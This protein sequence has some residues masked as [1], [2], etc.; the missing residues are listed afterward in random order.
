MNEDI[1]NKIQETKFEIMT[2]LNKSEEL[3][4]NISTELQSQSDVIEKT[5]SSITEIDSN[6]NIAKKLIG[7]ISSIFSIFKTS[8]GEL[9][10][11]NSDQNILRSNELPEEIITKKNNV[12]FTET[13]QLSDNDFYYEISESI[14]RIKEHTL[15]QSDILDSHLVKLD[16]LTT[17]VNN[18]DKNMTTM[19]NKINSVKKNY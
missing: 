1:K 7:N 13:M 19:I 2:Y 11:E 15:I 18:T 16:N 17:R 14:K 12:V 5:D 6:I 3:S 9:K 10:T 8:N 4:A